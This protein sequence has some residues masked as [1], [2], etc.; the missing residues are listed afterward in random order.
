MIILIMISHFI[1][2]ISM[3]TITSFI[4]TE[5]RSISHSI[6][7]IH[8][9]S[10]I[11]NIFTNHSCQYRHYLKN[12]CLLQKIQRKRKIMRIII[13]FSHHSFFHDRV[14]ILLIFMTSLNDNISRQTIMIYLFIYNNI[15]AISNY[16]IR[17]KKKLR[18]IDYNDEYKKR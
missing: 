15:F 14:C 17:Q 10:I 9:I 4:K 2:I 18:S 1:I 6:H 12:Y 13:I 16:F 3:I 11:I 7:N 5:K 8:S